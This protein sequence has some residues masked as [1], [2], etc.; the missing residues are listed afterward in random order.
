MI[1]QKYILDKQYRN[2]IKTKQIAIR[3]F[4]TDQLYTSYNDK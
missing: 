1:H 4:S 2:A 3:K